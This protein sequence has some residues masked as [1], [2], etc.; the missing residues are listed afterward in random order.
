MANGGVPKAAQWAVE[1]LNDPALFNGLPAND[2]KI[3]A[4]FDKVMASPFFKHQTPGAVYNERFNSPMDA[5]SLAFSRRLEP[6]QDLET[7]VLAGNAMFR[8][9]TL[10]SPYRAAWTLQRAVR[11]SPPENPKLAAELLAQAEA[12]IPKQSQYIRDARASRLHN[13]ATGSEQQ[14]WDLMAFA[15]DLRAALSGKQSLPTVDAPR[16]SETHTTEADEEQLLRELLGDLGDPDAAPARTLTAPDGSSHPDVR[17]IPGLIVSVD[18]D[19][20]TI[21]NFDEWSQ[22]FKE[23]QAGTYTGP[24]LKPFFVDIRTTDGG[25]TWESNMLTLGGGFP[26]LDGDALVHNAMSLLQQARGGS[27]PQRLSVQFPAFIPYKPD[28]VDLPDYAAMSELNRVPQNAE[29]IALGE[30]FGRVGHGRTGVVGTN[31]LRTETALKGGAPTAGDAVMQTPYGRVMSTYGYRP[32]EVTLTPNV[33]VV[34][35]LVKD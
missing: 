31:Y 15:K 8:G 22:A 21:G 28:L 12:I 17:D 19:H 11:T 16:A 14:L 5:D 4:T 24:P 7:E 3:Q 29:K 33:R 20:V 13:V 18:K 30:A 6:G 26:G 2:P 27:L 35:D 1:F 9:S 25:R 23:S 32:Y 34:G 10:E